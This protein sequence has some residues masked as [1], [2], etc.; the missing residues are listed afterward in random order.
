[1]L[2]NEVIDIEKDIKIYN[3][4]LAHVSVAF[5]YKEEMRKDIEMIYETDKYNFYKKA[6]DSNAYN[7]VTITM[8]GIEREFYAKKALGIILMA[9]EDTSICSKLMNLVKKYYS[10]IY[11]NIAKNQ[12]MELA[13]SLLLLSSNAQSPTEGKAY[14]NIAFYAMIKLNNEI[15]DKIQKRFVDS[16][17]DTMRIMQTETYVV[18]DEKAL[19]KSKREVI[20]SIKS[21]IEINKGRY[22]GFEDI[23]RT[24]NEEI[25]KYQSIIS[26]IFDFEKMSISALLSDIILNEEDVDKIIMSYLSFYSDKNLERTTNVLINGIIIQSLLKAYKNVKETFFKN[27]KETLYLNLEMLENNNDE[28]K[29]KNQILNEQIMNLNEEISLLKSNQT[30]E[31][32]KVKKQYEK[33]VNQLNKKIK[34]L[35]KE[36]KAEKKTVYIDEVNK[37]RETLFSIKNEYIPKQHLRTLND[38][39][40]KYNILIVGGA[41]EWRRRIKEKYPQILTIDGFNENFDANI[42]N[43][44]DFIF[45]FTGYMNHGTYYK[46]INHVRNKNIKF[47]YIGKTN[48]ELVENELIEE[49]EKTL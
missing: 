6:K 19:I 24:Q 31:I 41:A 4:I 23:Y 3:G 20:D 9:E 7:H 18:K 28:L 16:Y 48:L 30:S 33:L 15:K 13:T 8:A 17:I 40:E 49:I 37:L 25:Q 27:N 2:I 35:E 22:R 36:L 12:V 47:G 43:N 29:K 44:I 21:R 26:C 32:N 5:I 46:F 10:R 38:Y 42:L 11:L 45:F 14:E 34:T 1:M 39:L